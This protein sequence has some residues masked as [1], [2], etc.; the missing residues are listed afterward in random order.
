ME[1]PIAMPNQDP[2]P[3]P[4][5]VWGEYSEPEFCGPDKDLLLEWWS[6][7]KNGGSGQ[8]LRHWLSKDAVIKPLPQMRED[9]LR[10][11]KK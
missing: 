6:C 8:F 5:V 11:E 9:V 1:S 10:G 7:R 3:R 2:N 4:R